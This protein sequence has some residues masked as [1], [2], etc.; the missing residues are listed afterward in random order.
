MTST[1]SATTARPKTIKRMPVRVKPPNSS[2]PSRK[3][4]LHHNGRLDRAR[5][6]SAAARHKRH[7]IGD[8]RRRRRLRAAE[9]HALVRLPLRLR[10][11]RV[12]PV[13]RQERMAKPRAARLQAA[14]REHRV[15]ETGLRAQA[16]LGAVPAAR[17]PHAAR[18]DQR[19][20]LALQHFSVLPVPRAKRLLSP[21]PILQP[22][23]S[24]SLVLSLP[25]PLALRLKLTLPLAQISDF[26]RDLLAL[27]GA[28]KKAS[29]TPPPCAAPPPPSSCGTGRKPS[30]TTA[31]PLRRPRQQPALLPAHQAVP[32]PAPP[33]NGGGPRR[34]D[35]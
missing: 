31:T 33:R 5:P 20:L 16:D 19:P 18:R 23:E 25:L 22:S 7:R 10:P 4:D 11:R 28:S 24:P 17:E 9:S 14:G 26:L 21:L 27:F 13:P 32:L 2:A 30:S 8:G 6:I 29:D 3:A 12:I 1:S 35:Q 34:A 15:R